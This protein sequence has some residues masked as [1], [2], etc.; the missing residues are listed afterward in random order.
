[1]DLKQTKLT[2]DEWIAIERPVDPAEHDIISLIVD[3]Y[4]DVNA[5]RSTAHT[6]RGFLKVQDSKGIEEFI[7]VRYLQESL[8]RTLKS[9]NIPYTSLKAKTKTVKKADLIR[10]DNADKQLASQRETI[11]EYTMLELVAKLYKQKARKSKNWLLYYYTLIKLVGQDV[12][13]ANKTL[14]EQIDILLRGLSADVHPRDIF[15]RTALIVEGNPYLSRFR[16][17]ALYDHQRRLFTICKRPGPKLISYVAPTGTGK[18]LSPIGLLEGHRVI[19]VCAARHV[20]LALAKAAISAHRKIAFA[21]GCQG[22]DDIR[23]HYFAA[24]EY[25]KDKRSGGIGKVDNSVGDAVEMMICDVKSYIP[26]MRYMLAF[27][28]A[29]RIITY[30]DEPTI[31]LDYQE[32]EF[33][34]MIHQNWSENRI[35][36]MVLSS[37]T[38]PRSEDIIDS[39]MD[40]KVR[41]PDAQHYDIRSHECSKSVRIIDTLGEVVMPHTIATTY[42]DL[43]DVVSHCRAYPTLT[44]YFDVEAAVTFINHLHNV[45]GAQGERCDFE[46]RFPTVDAV[47]SSAVKEYYLDTL[48][49]LGQDTWEAL[50]HEE[51]GVKALD[52]WIHVLTKDAYTVTNGPAIFLTN[53]VAR[54]A[55]FYLGEVNIP[56]AVS[57]DLAT[58]IAHNR[59]IGAKIEGLEKNLEDLVGDDD[60][61]RKP[62]A[63]PLIK[64]IES[65]KNSIRAVMLPRMFIPNTREH[66]RRYVPDARYD[67]AAPDAFTCDITEQIVEEVMQIPDVDDTWKMLLLLGIGAFTEH[68]SRKYLEVMKRLADEQKLFMVIASG[69][70]V[71]G[72]NY[73][74]CHGF[75]GKDMANASQEKCIQA[76]GRVGRGKQNQSYS[77]RFRSE[78]LL[79]RLFHQASA[80]PEADNMQRLFS[81]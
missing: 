35:P 19:F 41:F 45:Y 40:Y 4:A 26:A 21:F 34:P 13:T 12:S 42:E 64:Q 33:H 44:R 16:D 1:M 81:A 43:L 52:S 37:A 66:M 22:A 61:H 15:K 47:T 30:W 10:F 74:F 39:I 38:L 20:G 3:G 14:L 17:L 58:A 50:S 5:R 78:E 56:T 69:D 8:Q 54:V 2:K 24:K 63:Q 53:D 75:L 9:H 23:L 29:E 60:G 73:Q 62:E 48:E 70:Y 49:S 51:F 80:K 27:N 6:L 32:H 11:F 79:R 28:R 77:V 46:A 71:Y 68:K 55:R 18:T 36:N 57:L 76:M 67:G 59:S 65:L 7:F 31:S 25:T 72:T